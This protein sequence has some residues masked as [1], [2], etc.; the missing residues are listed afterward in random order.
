MMKGSQMSEWINL[1]ASDG[2]KFKAYTAVPD[3][4]RGGI[5]VLQEIFGVTR[6]IRSIVDGFADAGYAAIAPALFDRAK[7][8]V[9][10][11]YSD[12]ASGKEIVSAVAPQDSAKDLA[13]SVQW[14]LQY[15]K[16][17]TV[18]YCWGGTLAFLA[19]SSLPV[20]G[21]VAYYG[22]MIAKFVDRKPKVPVMYHF[23]GLDAYIPETDIDAIRAALPSDELFV[24]ADAGHGFNCDERADFSP[25][26]AALARQRTLDFLGRTVG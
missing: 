21:A 13:A 8:D 24:Y 19:A 15:G 26:S 6:H 7:R 18:G 3:A 25:N 17:A 14:A 5:V 16:V 22:G 23:G 9:E 10:L 1:E 20:S 2:H 4:P 12:I 11:D